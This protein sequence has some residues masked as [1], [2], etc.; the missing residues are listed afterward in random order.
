MKH[1]CFPLVKTVQRKF[2]AEVDTFIFFSV[3][4]FLLDVVY[5][6]LLKLVNFSPSYSKNKNGG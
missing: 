2:V 3:V 4:M 5:Y 1:Y 6:K